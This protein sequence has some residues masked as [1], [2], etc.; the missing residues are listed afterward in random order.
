MSNRPRASLPPLAALLGPALALTSSL[1]LSRAAAQTPSV[2]ASSENVAQTL[3]EQGRQLM[4]Q[5]RYAEACPKFEESQRLDPASGT[6]LNLGDC[7]EHAGRLATAWTKFMDAAASAERAGKAVR[8]TEAQNRAG[9]LQA[10]LSK[11][12]ITAASNKLPGLQIRLDGTPVPATQWGTATPADPGEHTIDASAPGRQAFRT[13]VQLSREGE[14]ITVAVPELAAEGASAS[15]VDADSAQPH[16]L[17]RQK[18]LALAAGGFGAVGII[19]G[20]VFGLRSKSKHDD[21]SDACPSDPCRDQRG[22]DLWNDARSA[23]NLS[24]VAFIVGAAALGGGAV[25]W[26]TAEPQGKTALRGSPRVG[27]G[28]NSIRVGGEW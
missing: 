25:L 9:A 18:A 5:G 19:A 22:V 1:C 15:P 24:T 21:A 17:G 2:Q 27:V 23:G 26:L 6:L 12:V 28:W 14:T 20:T 3:F 16:R 11:L 8:A 10:R 4:E 13:S 7:Y